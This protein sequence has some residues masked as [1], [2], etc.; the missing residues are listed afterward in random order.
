MLNQVMWDLLFRTLHTF[1]LAKHSFNWIKVPY[2]N[3]LASVITYVSSL[4]YFLLILFLQRN[5]LS[6]RSTIYYS[7]FQRDLEIQTAFLVSI[8]SSNK[9]NG[10]SHTSSQD[11]SNS[12]DKVV[13][14]VNSG[15]I[16]FLILCWLT[17]EGLALVSI[18]LS[19]LL[20]V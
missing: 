3:P 15:T 12:S 13:F 2:D 8:S 1:G 19:I 6:G 17:E 9:L 4:A 7:L 10:V 11:A 16:K 18:I 5:V 20:T 14:F